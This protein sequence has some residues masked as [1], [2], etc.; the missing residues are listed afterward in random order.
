MQAVQADTGPGI[1]VLLHITTGMLRA[2]TRPPASRRCEEFTGG[3]APASRGW[4]APHALAS[5][6]TG[7]LVATDAC[8]GMTGEARAGARGAG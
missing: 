2:C 3:R 8:L 7:W 6:V 5:Q 4:W 1:W